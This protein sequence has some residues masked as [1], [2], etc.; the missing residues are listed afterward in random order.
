MS[1]ASRDAAE[2]VTAEP[3]TPAPARRRSFR[4]PR[5]LSRLGT[6]LA[7]AALTLALFPATVMAD[8][9]NTFT[10]TGPVLITEGVEHSYTVT[11][12]LDA[13]PDP[14]YVGT[15]DA[16][17]GTATCSIG[18]FTDGVAT[19][20]LQDSVVEGNS[21]T[22]TDHDAS[23]IT[24]TLAVHVLAAG[25]VTH[26]VFTPPAT[27]SVGVAAAFTVTAK[28]DLNTTDEAYAGPATISSTDASAVFTPSADPGFTLGVGT[29]NVAFS[30]AGL[31]TITATDDA[32]PAITGTSAPV[33]VREN[34]VITPTSTPPSPGLVGDLYE[35]TATAPGGVVD[36]TLDGTSSGCTI[37]TG[38]VT[39][40]GVGTCKILSD[41]VGDET[42]WP[43]PQLSQS[44]NV[45]YAS[46]ATIVS[47]R[48]GTPGASTYGQSITFTV[49]VISLHLTP[50]GTVQFYY[51]GSTVGAPVALDGSGI[52]TWTTT[53]LP[54]GT[55]SAHAVY[56]GNGTWA[57]ADS[58][59]VSQDVSSGGDSATVVVSS[60]GASPSGS[61]FGDTVTF[62][63]TVSGGGITPTGDVEFFDGA[64]SLGTDTL[65]GTGHARMSRSSWNLV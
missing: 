29:A 13:A 5:I 28:D 9:A 60:S 21:L 41:Q 65:D 19:A 37:D 35:P 64:T 45:R 46:T 58:N 34:Q 14:T 2:F 59:T 44:I 48:P 20:L 16:T 36:F 38:T 56:S 43:A 17:C 47:S 6:C 27:A 22:V 32:T 10:I 12:M 42:H 61:S 25:Q 52:A 53:T 4:A 31:P 30:A 7:I 57:A 49:T 15:A 39:F 55:Q 33:D 3:A 18:V 1:T 51:A 23:E 40:I 50:A 24:G 11:A 8:G 63:A 62:T 26:L 54:V